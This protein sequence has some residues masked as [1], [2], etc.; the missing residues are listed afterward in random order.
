MPTEQRET[1]YT[2]TE[3]PCSECARCEDWTTVVEA[4]II[5]PCPVCR[6]SEYKAWLYEAWLAGSGRTPAA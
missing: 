6:P 2:P 3:V 4:N 5:F 1:P